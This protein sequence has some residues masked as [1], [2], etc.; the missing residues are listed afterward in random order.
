MSNIL[1][2]GIN[3]L[4][5]FQ[6]AIS[7][8]SHN[9]TN[10]NTEGYSRQE[11]KFSTRESISFGAGYFGNGVSTEGARRVVDSF[12]SE[13][14]RDYSASH[15]ELSS[16]LSHA[17][18]VDTLL[19]DSSTGVSGSIQ[20]F[21][22]SV[23]AVV[24]EPSYLPAREI[25]LS[26]SKILVDRFHSLDNQLRQ[27]IS[28]VNTEMSII[29]NQVTSLA[30]SIAQ[31]NSSIAGVA[32][33]P[34]DLLDQRDILL[35]ELSGLVN[36]ITTD[37]E[38]GSKNVLIG[39]GQSLVLGGEYS[40]LNVAN[41]DTDEFDLVFDTPNGQIK[42]TE[43]ITSGELGGL[44][45]FKREVLDQAVNNV[46]LMAIS[47]ASQINEQHQLG[48]DLNNNL[49][50]FFFS[51]INSTAAMAERVTPSS[52][53]TGSGSLSV[54]IDNVADLLPTSYRLNVIS[55]SNYELTRES[56]N[57]IVSTGS[58][59]SLP[60]NINVDGFTI[61]VASGTF[62]AGD[63]YE[64]FPV[65][66]GARDVSLAATNITAFAIAS[67]IRTESSINNSGTGSI[68]AGVISDV[69]NSAFTTTPGALSPPVRIEFLT[70]T[71]YQVLNDITGAVLDAGPLTYDPSV[72]N[73][74]FP[75]SGGYDPG[76]QVEIDG[77]PEAGD[78]FSIEYNTGGINDNRNGTLL[79]ETQIAKVLKSG[80]ASFQEF[81]GQLIA[82]VGT[83][84]NQASINHEAT[85]GLLEQSE[86][87]RD[88]ISGV[89]L[90][91]EAA[92]LLKYQQAYQASARVVSVA[93]ELMAV[94]F[95][96][97]GG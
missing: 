55:G 32:E 90:D 81:Y 83:S 62:N 19:S 79:A 75:T 47:M 59:A 80:T 53:N 57:S 22:S 21:Y 69:S 40:N 43:D 76:Y 2:L 97:L 78:I 63:S 18:R 49:G 84:T 50:G 88:S 30:K 46:G 26:N 7:T 10:V 93:Q 45:R 44:L 23:Q 96:A 68:S 11:V 3:G 58:L 35:K 91:Q 72:K 74:I 41:I 86:A 14:I 38:D 70:A 61:N 71:T 8:T 89:N 6:R 82:E 13:Q 29:S 77:A 65:S 67:P 87:R 12:I 64:V 92:D 9:I 95:N 34:P 54:A 15:G 17:L 48:M 52:L 94:L 37:Q 28:S 85:K 33:A 31:L 16:Y 42:I 36:I 24:D 1:N 39:S 51:D 66:S 73:A 56:D 5:A 25:L 20:D 60:V 4:L 27:E